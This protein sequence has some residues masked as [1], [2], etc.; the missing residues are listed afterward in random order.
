MATNN[1]FNQSREGSTIKA[2]IVAKYFSAWAKKM[3]QASNMLYPRRKI[4]YIDLCSGPGRYEDGQPSTPLLVLKK[5]LEDNNISQQLIS[6]FVDH[7][8][9]YI[10]KLK[11]EIN[12]IPDIN[13]LKY[14]PKTYNEVVND[15]TIG[16]WQQDEATP[17]LAFL[18]PWGYAPISLK[19]FYSIIK[20]WGCDCIFYFNF[21]RINMHIERSQYLSIMEKIFSPDG[22]TK[23]VD[24]LNLSK[25]PI[26]RERIIIEELI[27]SLNKLGG[28]YTSRFRF[29]NP[30]NKQRYYLFLVSKNPLAYEIMNNIMAPHS[31]STAQD[32]KSFEFDP[33]KNKESGW[34]FESQLPLDDLMEFLLKDFTGETIT[35]KKIF[36]NHPVKRP[37]IRPYTVTNYKDA[38]LRLESD[39]KIQVNPPADRRQVRNGKLTLVDTAEI[40]FP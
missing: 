40:T 24:R 1:F 34:L 35:V 13:R 14:P 12:Q 28:I 21:N 9:E 16:I 38:L 3:T 5:A 37:N 20:G 39:K 33:T 26:D 10:N 32:V 2:E 23:L 11:N 15:Q 7:N 8:K 6:I 27:L 31:T 19:M 17:T 29:V 22:A 30:K 18:D 25:T 36:S 4:A